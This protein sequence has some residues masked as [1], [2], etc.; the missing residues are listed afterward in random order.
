M[1]GVPLTDLGL[2]ASPQEGRCGVVQWCRETRGHTIN[3]F[4]HYIHSEHLSLEIAIR[5]DIYLYTLY[6]YMCV[7][8][9]FPYI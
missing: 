8:G 7:C 1:A 5:R 3:L 4:V 9:F 6:I 2:R